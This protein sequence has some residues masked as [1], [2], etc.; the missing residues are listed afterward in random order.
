MSPAELI[1]FIG[2]LVT[3]I[4]GAF[5]LAAVFGARRKKFNKRAE[6]LRQRL[7]AQAAGARAAEH[8]DL[9]R[10]DPK[11]FPVI[12]A[13]VNR[14]LPKP[15][16][17]RARLDR[18]GKRISIGGYA[19]VSLA[20]AAA[21]AVSAAAAAGLSL[22]PAVFAGLAAGLILPHKVVGFLGARRAKRFTN[23]F[24]DA[25][26]LMV[27]GLKSGLPVSEC[28]ASIGTEMADPVGL[29]FRAIADA[30]RLGQNFDDALWATA[31]RL[32]T[33][34]FNF[35][36]ITLNVQRETGGN[37]AET[38]ANLSDIL[39]KRKQ[40]KQKVKAMSSE[41]R[42]S[43]YILGSLPFL[44]LAILMVLNADYAMMLFTD[45]RG[46]TAVGVGVAMLVTGVGIMFKMVRFEP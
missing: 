41:A 25:I 4:A 45:P 14:L 33:A 34:D 22:L 20:V 21:A 26:D 11:R 3:F 1:F 30:V 28:I 8:G 5:G 17:L 42:A 36:V 35:F 44:M 9:R 13:I 18:T 27:R 39:R 10:I 46:H 12:E 37:L 24:P 23:L 15:Q 19:G 16:I 43:A 38:L 40:M 32:D 29:E 7:S 2:A 6:K 31:R